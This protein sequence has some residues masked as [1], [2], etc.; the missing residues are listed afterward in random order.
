MNIQL[1]KALITKLRMSDVDNLGSIKVLR[2]EYAKNIR[3]S[4]ENKENRK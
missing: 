4:D 2:F 1:N 3:K